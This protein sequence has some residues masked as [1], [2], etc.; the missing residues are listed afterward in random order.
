M[1]SSGQ[2]VRASHFLI[3]HAESRNPVSRRTNESTANYAKAAA[4]DEMHKWIAELEKDTRPL[5]EKFAALAL[6]R[7]DCGSYKD[8]GD[9]GYFGVGDMQKPFEDATFAT[10]VGEVSG[11]VDSDSGW[12]I[13]YRTA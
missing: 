1:A 9:L 4:L 5:P 11:V 7:S 12:H 8:G 6:H 2:S 3:K 13:I 10:Q